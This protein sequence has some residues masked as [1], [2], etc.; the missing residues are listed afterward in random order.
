MKNESVH[1]PLRTHHLDFA[2]TL[3]STLRKMGREDLHITDALQA[4][5]TDETQLNVAELSADDLLFFQLLNWIACHA[6]EGFQS[7]TQS[8]REYD[9][10]LVGEDP[11]LFSH[12]IDKL[13]MASIRSIVA[14]YL[15]GTLLSLGDVLDGHCLACAK[16]LHCT[17]LKTDDRAILFQLKNFIEGI[18]APTP[19]KSD[20]PLDKDL[21]ETVSSEKVRAFLE[22]RADSILIDQLQ[23]EDGI[24]KIPKMFRFLLITRKRRRVKLDSQ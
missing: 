8:L 13:V 20:I 2:F 16:A 14:V 19:R 23:L 10:D 11:N 15:T 5:L 1:F 6:R 22:N 24:I 9:M 7:R 3:T 12:Y 17:E 18:E 4:L 21:V